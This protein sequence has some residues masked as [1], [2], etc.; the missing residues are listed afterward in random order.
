MWLL[1]DTSARWENATGPKKMREF[2][3]WDVFKVNKW[4]GGGHVRAHS[5]RIVCNISSTRNLIFMFI[6]N[7]HRHFVAHK[8]STNTPYIT[9][10]PCVR[11]FS[12]IFKFKCAAEKNNENKKSTC[13]QSTFFPHQ[14]GN[15]AFY[16][17]LFYS[18]DWLLLILMLCVCVVGVIVDGD[19]AGWS[20]LITLCAIDLHLYVFLCFHLDPS[21]YVMD[22]FL[23]T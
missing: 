15:D 9:I 6:E 2:H 20:V 5:N 12:L 23:S 11:Q 10:G 18:F 22:M 4:Y 13:T 7:S 16:Y 19:I 3:I 14:N 21:C 1:P 8:I 17:C